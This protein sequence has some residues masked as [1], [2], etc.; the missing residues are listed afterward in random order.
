MPHQSL[1]SLELRSEEVQEVLSYIPHWIVRW[2]ITVFCAVVVAIF[3]LSWVMRYPDVLPTKVM[4]VTQNPPVHVQTRS[5]GKLMSLQVVDNAQVKAGTVL[6]VIDNTSSTDDVRVLKSLL[7]S[8]QPLLLA[9]ATQE[10][11]RVRTRELPNNPRLGE[12]QAEYTSFV[13]AFA[14]YATFQQVFTRYYAGRIAAL[15]QQL[16]SYNE[17][18]AKLMKQ[19]DI[20]RREEEMAQKKFDADKSLHAKSFLSDIELNGSESGYLAKKSAMESAE[21]AI[22]NNNVQI[23]TLQRTILDMKQQ[24]EEK[25]RSTLVALQESSHRLQSSIAGWEQRYLITAPADGKV[26]LTKFWSESQYVTSG[27]EVLTIIPGEQRVVGKITMPIAGSGKVK[28]GQRVNI[29]FDS[30]PFQEFGSVEAVVESISLVPSNNQ[31]IV[32]ITLPHGLTTTYNKTLEFKQEMQGSADIITEDLR[33]IERIF[34]Q[35]RSLFTS[36]VH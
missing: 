32:T 15:E 13:Q 2:G 14:E 3:V 5:A 25:E 23:A 6:A 36:A 16:A 31:Y 4:I 8:L 34:Y 12:L 24:A 1:E 9:N 22:V 27:E 29:K 11:L 30:Y 21:S 35:F 10:L 20:A 33:L 19:R 7:A 18:T 28:A 17:L 26:S